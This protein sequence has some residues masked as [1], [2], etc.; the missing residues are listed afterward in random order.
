MAR[1]VF[2][3]IKGVCMKRFWNNLPQVWSTT[4]YLKAK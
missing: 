1:Q 3:D 4:K 2:N